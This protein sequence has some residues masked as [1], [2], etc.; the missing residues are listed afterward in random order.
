MQEYSSDRDTPSSPGIF[1]EL[2]QEQDLPQLFSEGYIRLPLCSA[3]GEVMHQVV[4]YLKGCGISA[5]SLQSRKVMHNE[6]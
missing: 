5:E 6:R 4:L 3:D 1:I 2:T